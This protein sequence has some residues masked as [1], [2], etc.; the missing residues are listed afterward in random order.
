MDCIFLVVWNPWAQKAMAMSDFGDDEVCSINAQFFFKNIAFSEGRT[1]GSL[2]EF[3]GRK[4]NE[5]RIK[6]FKFH[7]PESRK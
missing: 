5:S 2:A 7:F 6:E 4:T 1:G 3:K